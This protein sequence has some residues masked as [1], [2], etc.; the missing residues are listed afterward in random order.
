MV[1]GVAFMSEV[2]ETMGQG[3]WK[4]IIDG[5]E[6][7]VRDRNGF[8]HPNLHRRSNSEDSGSHCKV[9]IYG[10][11]SYRYTEIVTHNEESTDSEIP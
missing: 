5:S 4:Q 1:M 11:D 9:G 2:I 8:T 3:I 7:A 10:L 6:E